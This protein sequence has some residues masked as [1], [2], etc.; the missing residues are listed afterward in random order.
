MHRRTIALELACLATLCLGDHPAARAESM[1]PLQTQ[2]TTPD[3]S[4]TSTNW[5][6]GTPG[7]TNPFV[8]S[9]FDPRLGSLDAVVMTL[10]ATVRNDYTVNIVATPNPTTIYV[11]DTATSD[12]SVLT[13]PTK[14]AQLTDGPTVTLYAPDGV[15]QIFG[16]P[17]TTQPVSYKAFTS[18][19]TTTFSGVLTQTTTTYT[20]T[21]DSSDAP[22]SLLAEFI[23]T[24]INL[25]LNVI[26][27]A[28]SSFYSDTGNGSGE[29]LTS[30][31]ATATIQYLYT[32]THIS[33]PEP[34][35][36]LL[37]ALGT[38][39]GFLTYRRH[40]RATHPAESDRA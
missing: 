22:P 28:F 5:G 17:G 23:G 40:R 29:I 15:T 26:A 32:P 2:S 18:A 39:G 1:T 19:T 14:L 30:A 27:S 20:R 7:I 16:A 36:A 33:I 3:G 9:A 37:L 34:S 13:D 35:S 11:A 31:N 4:L 6:P 8:F 10:T 38:G 21:L 12:P 25:D 24:D